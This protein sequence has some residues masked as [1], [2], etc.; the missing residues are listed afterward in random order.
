MRTLYMTSRWPQTMPTSILDHVWCL[1]NSQRCPWPVLPSESRSVMPHPLLHCSQHL[2]PRCSKKRRGAPGIHQSCMSG[3]PGFL[4]TTVI[5]I[6]VARPYTTESWEPLQLDIALFVQ[7]SHD[8]CPGTVGMAL[9]GKQPMAILHVYNGKD[10]FVWLLT[11]TSSPLVWG[12]SFVFLLHI[13]H[14]KAEVAYCHHGL[15]SSAWCRCPLQFYISLNFSPCYYEPA[16]SA[17]R[18]CISL[19]YTEI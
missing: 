17:L 7:Q 4:E 13:H 8:M 6:Y 18:T 1:K 16:S 2:A 10:V 3:S 14:C 12:L 9:Q 19:H 5:L 11:D 15:G